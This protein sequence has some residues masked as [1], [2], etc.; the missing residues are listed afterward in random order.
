MEFA[1]PQLKKNLKEHNNN[2]KEIKIKSSEYNKR[3]IIAKQV[4]NTN[5]IKLEPVFIEVQPTFT[6]N[7]P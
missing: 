2:R 5:K 3:Q 6:I 7:T 1:L 4:D